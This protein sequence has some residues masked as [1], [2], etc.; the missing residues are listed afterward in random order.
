MQ[1]GLTLLLAPSTSLSCTLIVLPLF[2]F[3]FKLVAV[4]FNFTARIVAIFHLEA[5]NFGSVC[6][7]RLLFFVRCP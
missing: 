6:V 4:S 5:I 3:Q 2:L 7:V 1:G